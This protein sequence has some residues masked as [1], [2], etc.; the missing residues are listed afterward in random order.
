MA[1][2]KNAKNIT[3]NC[4]KIDDKSNLKSERYQCIYCN[5]SYIYEKSLENHIKKK[6]SDDIINNME[7][8]IDED[9]MND[10]NKII[11][12]KININI[13]NKDGTIDMK[14]LNSDI[15]NKE[16]VINNSNNN[17]NGLYCHMIY[18]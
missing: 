4:S 14:S 12:S 15:N 11:N 7:D 1:Y 10:I 3:K 8:D 5:K 6:H 17:I 2:S 18:L 16:V 13:K 9:D